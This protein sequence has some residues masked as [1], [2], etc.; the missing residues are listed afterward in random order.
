MTNE[1]LV[2]LIAALATVAGALI[3]FIGSYL[4]LRYNYKSLY[5]DVISK[6]RM[7]WINAYRDEVATIVMCLRMPQ[8]KDKD[9]KDRY[10]CDAEKARAQLLTRLNFDTSKLENK[11]NIDFAELL[12]SIDFQADNSKNG[13]AE[14]II[15]ASKYILELEWKRVKKEA[16]G[17]YK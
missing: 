9:K 3:G 11:L 15:E 5:A 6:S 8:N 14:R 4:L 17:E 12:E 1:L 16:K 2:G 7:E 13:K 10:I